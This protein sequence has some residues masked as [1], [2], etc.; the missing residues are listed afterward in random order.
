MSVL[1]LLTLG[2]FKASETISY[3]PEINKDDLTPNPDG[4]HRLEL[5]GS[6]YVL[7]VLENGGI[8]VQS[9]D[10]EVIISSLAYYA[11]NEDSNEKWGLDKV[12]AN[13]SSDSTISISGEGQPG[14]QINILLTVPKDKPKLNVSVKTSYNINT[15]VTRESLVVGFDVSVSE[16]YRKNRQVD[17]E[18]FDSEYWL[19]REG[20]RFG[21]GNRSALIY[22]NPFVSSLQLDTRN[23]L[24]FINLEYNLD[25]PFIHI[26]YQE[27]GGGRW[28]DLSSAKYSAGDER[29]NN[30]SVYFG[31]SPKAIP[32]LMLVPGGNVAGYIFTEHADGGNIRTH[33]AAYFGSEE[34]SRIE[35]ATGG[36]AGHGIPVTKS[37]FYPD[38]KISPDS[39]KRNNGDR[40]QYQDFL[41]QLYHTGKYD[42][43]LHGSSST[44]E[45]F[46]ESLIFMKERFDEV[47]W[48]DHGMFSG[49]RHRTSFVGDALN[50]ESKHYVADL[51]EKYDVRYFWNAAVE[52]LIKYPLKEKL[53]Q[54]KLYDASVNLW[55]S[56]LSPKEISEMRF[57]VAFRE[58]VKRLLEKRTLK[59]LLPDKGNA[60]PTPLFW[61]H[62]TRTK[63]FYSWAT[64]FV[65]V[66][67]R[68]ETG[69]K[70]EQVRLDKQ[71][72]DWGIFIN[73]GYF[74][75]NNYDDGVL[76]EQNGK[77]VIDPYFD[78]TLEIIA[79]NCEKGDLYT[80]TIRD[81]LDY[82]VLIE[83]ISFDYLDDGT[84]Y[85]NNLNDKDISGLSLAMKADIARVDGVV[86]A[87]RRVGDDTIFWFDIPAG[88]GVRLEV[89]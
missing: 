33:R 75:R 51:W 31:S 84:I 35:D 27:D 74:V 7:S 5:K 56:F 76:S 47:T 12:S 44:R 19:Q 70:D 78:K 64:D 58:L 29:I 46:E 30:F 87:Y 6:K 3:L 39:S 37:V 66:F 72:S 60:F 22:H 4:L 81:L 25:H 73:H 28:V 65:K 17:H 18:H 15:V 26:P 38:L 69:V 55:K 59:L 43:C 67:H 49:K 89:E 68:S 23:E 54:F 63:N 9:I 71:I 42:I 77:I 52:E 10:G 85:I 61:Q 14:V 1:T 2:Y 83:N 79:A 86:P 82:W 80:T 41:D 48:I 57:D 53:Y 40:T 21:K 32:R 13:A 20:V 88:Q 8:T 11:S 24:L 50:P 36:F 34:I 16:V 45:L 62:P